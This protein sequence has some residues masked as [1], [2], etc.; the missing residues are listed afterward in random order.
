MGGLDAL[1]KSFMPQTEFPLKEWPTTQLP[2]RPTFKLPSGPNFKIPFELPEDLQQID[3]GDLW[4]AIIGGNNS[5]PSVTLPESP[6]NNGL[7]SI[8]GLITLPFNPDTDS[9]ELITLPFNPETDA[10]EM[11]TLPYRPNN[12]SS[13]LPLEALIPLGLAY[14]TEGGDLTGFSIGVYPEANSSDG[15]TP[16]FGVDNLEAPPDSNFGV[17]PNDEIQLF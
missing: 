12:Q 11:I 3:A 15:A 13:V 14:K 16:D 7:G 10:G 1:N 5:K 2:D 4:D 9:S 17:S 6:W 8:P